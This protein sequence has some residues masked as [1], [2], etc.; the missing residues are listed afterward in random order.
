[1]MGGGRCIDRR[2]EWSSR[3]MRR[4][5]NHGR[6]CVTRGLC[7]RGAGLRRRV[8]G[9][10]S[11]TFLWWVVSFLRFGRVASVGDVCLGL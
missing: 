6:W 10:R 5:G 3:G 11:G 4:F 1:M 2:Y 9:E 8:G 7:V